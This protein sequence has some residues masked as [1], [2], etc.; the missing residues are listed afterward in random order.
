MQAYNP[1]ELEPR[2]QKAWED[3]NLYATPDPRTSGRPKKY[4][5][6]MFPYPSGDIH[7]GHVSNYTYGDVVARYSR[8]RG[9]DVLHPMGWDA[10]G[11]PAENAAIKHHSHP[12][13]WTYANIDA[14]KA[15]FKRMGFSYDWDRTV[16]ACDPEYY[17]WGQWIFL[18]FWERGLVERRN[19]PVNWCP[20]CK[21]VLANEQVI[22]GRCWRCDSA[23]EKRDLTQWYFKITDYAQQLLADL[24]QL[25]GW[26]ER[27]KQQQANWIGR[28]EGAQVDF[29]LMPM[30]VEDMAA[31]E[32]AAADGPAITV[33]TTRAD[34][35][36]GCSFFVLAPEYAGLAELVAGAPQE[37]EQGVLD[38][39]E[40]AKKITAVQRAQGNHEST[41]RSP[42]AYVGATPSTANTCPCGSPTTWWPTTAREPSWPSRCGDQRDF[43]FARNYDLPIER[44]HPAGGR[45]ACTAGSRT[46]ADTVVTS[47]ELAG[48]AMPPR[49]CWCK[50][51]LIR[52]WRAAST[53]A[54][55]EAVVGG[56][57]G[58][59][60][61]GGCTVELPP[62]R[63][64]CRS[65]AS[66]TG[67][68]PIPARCT[69]STAARCPCRRTSCR[70]CCPEDVRLGGG[71]RRPPGHARGLRG[72]HLPRVRPA[73]RGARPDTHGHLHVL[74]LVLHA[75][76]R[77]AQR[78]GTLRPRQGQRLDARGPV[79]RR[80]RARH[81]AFAVQPLLH[82]GAARLRHA[83]LRR[84]VHEPAVPGHGAGCERRGHEQVEGQ[85]GVPRGDDQ[86]LRR[87]CG[88]RGHAVHGAAGQG[89]AV[90]RGRPGGH[91]QVSLPR[92]APGDRPCGAGRRGHVL[93]AGRVAL[94]RPG[95]A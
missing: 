32:V 23:V 5:L 33:F 95:G 6:E 84:A 14:Q 64:G 71:R 35:L 25:E 36:F 91:V 18:K 11:L 52:A 76:H 93:P 89:E 60:S 31:D 19:S 48:R 87:R 43:E 72:H 62:A 82:E 28:S 2:W 26:P 20:D 54:G 68:T 90:E 78:R 56:A 38:L 17:R 10:F 34:T 83:G 75:L 70:C 16:V 13:K 79:H 29:T 49:A 42:A 40:T 85:R 65:A 67:A 53:Q 58:G 37:A 63:L 66:A 61:T 3:E 74:Q 55:E 12:A 8:M 9:F 22:E 30:G 15:S 86:G 46:S 21:T 39:I 92:V 7:M 94:R 59:R 69:A 57:G 24:D 81:P 80:H 41:A 88:A 73:R 47:V 77:P 44:R 51:G 27:V 4:V 50:R 1:Q 45:P